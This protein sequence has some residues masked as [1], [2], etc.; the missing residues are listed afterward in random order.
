MI[1]AVRDLW[2]ELCD[3]RCITTNGT[4]KK[5]GSSVMGRG[6]ASE[7]KAIYADI[8]TYLGARLKAYGNHTQVLIYDKNIAL[9]SFPVKHNWWERADIELIKRSAGE[10]VIMTEIQQWAKVLLPR[11][12]CGNGQL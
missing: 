1:E 7:A 2:D 6:C 3:A 9:V 5:D 12:G 4:M 8:D 10:L 11:P